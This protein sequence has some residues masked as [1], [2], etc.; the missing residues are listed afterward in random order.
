LKTL[1]FKYNN[2]YSKKKRK[3]ILQIKILK[4][5]AYR[6]R[7]SVNLTESILG[8][9]GHNHPEIW[10]SFNILKTK[11]MI[12]RMS[13]SNPGIGQQMGKGR[14][15]IYYKITEQGFFA[16]II[17]GI[18]P[19]EFWHVLL[20]FCHYSSI[21][22]SLDIVDRFYQ[23][24]LQNY[25]KYRSG[26]R[27]LLSQLDIFNEM[28]TRWIDNNICNNKESSLN[29]KILEI[30]GKN[31]KLSLQ[32][33]AKKSE[34]PIDK[35]KKAIREQTT[36]RGQSSSFLIGDDEYFD[37]NT[38]HD[39]WIDMLYHNIV[40]ISNNS[41]GVNETY[42][43]S[44]FGVMLMLTLIRYQDMNRLNLYLFNKFTIQESFDIMALNY[45]EKLPLI[46]GEWDLLKRI[47]KI[48]A[49]Y[50]FD[51]IIDKEARFR[52]MDVSV[53]MD[54]NKEYYDSLLGVAAYSHKQLIELFEAGISALTNYKVRSRSKDDDYY[55]WNNGNILSQNNEELANKK[56]IAIHQKLTEIEI[57][58]MY[59][60]PDVLKDQLNKDANTNNFLK[61]ISR[62][63]TVSILEK[64]FE[65]EITFLYYLNLNIRIYVPLIFPQNDY[66]NM[67][68]IPPAKKQAQEFWSRKYDPYSLA[69][70]KNMTLPKSPKERLIEILNHD[71][72]I[73]NMFVNSITDSI[74]YYKQAEVS[75]S[76]FL[77]DIAQ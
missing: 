58:L 13:N 59:L 61:H 21:N 18:E 2:W 8:K 63:S 20:G 49:V 47:L 14:H 28:C 70:Q 45:A 16:L 68:T 71:Q 36:Q 51:I 35:V 32:D 65:E 38:L 66:F 52:A 60:E 3:P 75:M 4:L 74:S 67:A 9:E 23:F 15:K 77:N 64:S 48:L 43:L 46:F 39:V 41:N 57:L 54:G 6:G 22:I 44:L 62:L 53:N 50:N 19:K 34:E 72:Q 11:G 76:N 17:E 73:K 27:H 33:L 25:L 69:P 26:E 12:E 55:L 37:S 10:H 42:S 29:Q 1:L 31:P 40:T 24:F 56:S 5:I 7:L 30:L